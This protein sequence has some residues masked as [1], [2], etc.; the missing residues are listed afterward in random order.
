MKIRNFKPTDAE[1]VAKLSND[2]SD[3][4]QYSDVSEAFLRKM[5]EDPS[6]HMFVLSDGNAI[7]G[8]CGVNYLQLPLAELG[9]ICVVAGRRGEG[10]GRLLV[11]S[12]LEFLE[13]LNAKKLFIKVKVSNTEALDFFEKL[14]FIREG[15]VSV[16]GT[17][18][19]FM[20]LDLG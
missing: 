6:Y 18:A 13:P 20:S 11:D 4:F 17:P 19:I 8:F 12:I 7:I 3:V 1:K 2:N 15:D 10:L 16:G 5:S 9:P 14:D